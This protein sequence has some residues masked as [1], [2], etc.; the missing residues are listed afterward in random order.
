MICAME[1]WDLY[2]ENRLPL[3]K[4][5]VRGQEK[6]V[7][8]E[9]RAVVHVCL[10]ST[11]GKMLI[12]RRQ[13]FKEGW[14]GKWDV[15]VGG[16]AIAGETPKEAAERELKEELGIALPLPRQRLTVNFESGFDDIFL[17]TRDVAL[18]SL[19]LQETEV[20]EVR[21]ATETEIIELLHEKAF[22]PYHESLIRLLFA[23]RKHYGTIEEKI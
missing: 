22:I 12:Q 2:D 5:I 18:D 15:T 19:V 3:G 17:V 7:A 11:D 1:L 4:Q 14:S 23:M 6:P 21:W 16:S 10:F 20:A 8:G 13:P 9:Y